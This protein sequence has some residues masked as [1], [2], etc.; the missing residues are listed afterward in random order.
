MGL[1]V[2]DP[3][4]PWWRGLWSTTYQYWDFYTAD[5]GPGL[6]PDGPGPLD[7]GPPYVTGYLPST[8]LQVFPLGDWIDID[9]ATGREGIWPLSGWIDVIVDNHNPPN[10]E[11][12]IRVQVFWRPQDPSDPLS[13]PA[14]E[15]I[16]P[17]PSKMPLQLIGR[18]DLG[19]GWYEDTFEWRLDFNPPDEIFTISGNI[20][21]DALVV[22]T[23]CIPEPTTLSVLALGVLALLR[24]SRWCWT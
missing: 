2:V 19:D 10:L 16:N 7:E 17:P 5:P 1:G 24:R 14:I 13:V 9:P 18:Y 21:V 23:W 12:R 11:K 20:D 3:Q 4:A 6:K 22:D 8:E 15:N